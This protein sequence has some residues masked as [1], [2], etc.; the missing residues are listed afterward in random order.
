[1]Q[2]STRCNN[3]SR[4]FRQVSLPSSHTL[5]ISFYDALQFVKHVNFLFLIWSSLHRA[6]EALVTALPAQAPHGPASPPSTAQQHAAERGHFPLVLDS[7]SLPI[8]ARSSRNP[9]S[10][11]NLHPR[12][13]GSSRMGGGISCAPESGPQPCASCHVAA[14]GSLHPRRYSS[15]LFTPGTNVP[16]P[17]GLGQLTDSRVGRPTSPCSGLSSAEDAPWLLDSHSIR[18]LDEIALVSCY[19]AFLLLQQVRGSSSGS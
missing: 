17:A 6:D 15:C 18:E 7:L 3:L 14:R 1:M 11:E 4:E 10:S 9:S 12:A 16:G 2:D 8:P 13:C 5:S 19:Q